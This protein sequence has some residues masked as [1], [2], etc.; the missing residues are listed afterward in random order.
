V[1]REVRFALPHWSPVGVLVNGPDEV[2]DMEG[3]PVRKVVLDTER[4]ELSSAH[5]ATRIERFRTSG[6][7]YLL[8][9]ADVYPWLERHPELKRYLRTQFRRVEADEAV[10][11]LYALDAATTESDDVADD[12]LPLPPPEMVGLVAGD[13]R[14]EDFF[15]YGR[16]A[17][18][19]IA[20]MLERNGVSPSGLGSLLD[21]GCGCGRV[22][23]HWPGFTNAQLSGCDYNPYLVRWCAE[24]LPFGDFRV[25]ELEPPLPFEDESFD[26]VYSLSIFTHL[27]ADLQRPWIDELTRVTKPGGVL[28]PTF[29]GRSRVEFMYGND[30]YDR[31]APRFEAGELVVLEGA[32]AGSNEC[33]VYHPE[34]YVRDV[35]GQDL[36]LLDFSPAGA[37]DIQ[38]DAV[39]FR[40]PARA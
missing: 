12:G 15:R 3:R 14:R 19:W 1:E 9:P 22:I 33:A 32:A 25:N 11:R 40:K 10:C 24:N 4:T 7:R 37:L 6:V 13:S 17:A 18:T 26:L 2:P 30:L 34:R 16:Y 23:R 35:L 38:Q 5:V 8:V 21:F 31:V 36:E 27:H 39:L 28:L 20:E 29:H